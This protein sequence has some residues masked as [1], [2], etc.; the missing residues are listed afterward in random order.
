MSKK[1]K[2]RA[3]WHQATSNTFQC[4]YYFNFIASRMKAVIVTL[5]LWG[6]FPMCL[7]KWIN[8]RGGQCND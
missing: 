6:W 2:G 7:A 3:G 8:N 4:A 5:A 1:I